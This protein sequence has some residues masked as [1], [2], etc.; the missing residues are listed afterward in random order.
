MPSPRSKL[1]GH[2]G[3]AADSRLLRDIQ[4]RTTPI[5]NATLPPGGRQGRTLLNGW[6]VNAAKHHIHVVEYC[7][8]ARKDQAASADETHLAWL[9]C[10]QGGIGGSVRVLKKGVLEA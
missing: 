4:F 6:K 8:A 5:P 7:N 10:I 1:F 2:Y 3:K 9:G